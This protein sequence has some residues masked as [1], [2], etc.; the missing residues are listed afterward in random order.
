M[1]GLIFT[2][3]Y[4]VKQTSYYWVGDSTAVTRSNIEADIKSL[5]VEN[6]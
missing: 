4:A 3:S 6:V 1:P 2:I 5:V